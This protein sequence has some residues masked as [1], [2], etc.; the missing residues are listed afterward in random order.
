MNFRQISWLR[1]NILVFFSFQITLRNFKYY[2]KRFIDI[3]INKTIQLAA[4]IIR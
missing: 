1:I 2:N 3:K 4:S